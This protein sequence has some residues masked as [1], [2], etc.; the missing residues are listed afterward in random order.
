MRGVLDA[1]VGNLRRP[2]SVRASIENPAVPISSDEV[3][4]IIGGQLDSIAGVPVTEKK[5]LGYTP[6][7]RG[8]NTL[9][10][11][12]AKV[13]LYV[14]RREA[15][16]EN[17]LR[18]K[19]HP[20]YWLLR[21][22]PNAHLKPFTWKKVMFQH[23]LMRGNGYSFIRRPMRG[24]RPLSLHM[25]PPTPITT[26]IYDSEVG[27][28]FYH[29]NIRGVD[30]LYRAEDVVHLQGMTLDGIAGLEGVDVLSVMTDAIGVQLAQ[31][32]HTGRFFAAGTQTVG[33]LHAP[34]RFTEDQLE[35]IRGQWPGLR[36]EV[37]AAHSLALLYGQGLQYTPL[38]IDP[39][40]SQ[41]VQARELGMIE[42]ANMLGMPA[43]KVGSSA[44]VSYNSL[45][46]ENADYL[47]T[48]LDQWFVAME[49]ELE[50]KLLTVREQEDD[51]LYIEFDRE[52]LLRVDFAARIRGYI[53]LRE[54]GGMTGNQV[55]SRLG[56]PL[57]GAAGNR[58]Y[59][60]QTWVPIDDQGLP[61]RAS[62][63]P[64]DGDA[65]DATA[66]SDGARCAHRAAIA[67]AAS[68]V[69]RIESRRLSS[70]NPPTMSAAKQWTAK[71]YAEIRA[72]LA[73]ELAFPVAAYYASAD[74]SSDCQLA[75]ERVAESYVHL[76][77]GRVDKL[78]GAG[79]GNG[80]DTPAS[81]A[82]AAPGW[83]QRA[84]EVA[85]VLCPI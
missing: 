66:L 64:D 26:P 18:A 69:L 34:K 82:D 48:T 38:G 5:A 39:E 83:E 35:A 46:Q 42:T 45:E 72:M 14:M 84:A 74:D 17:A 27:E 29:T 2:A 13:P 79:G 77:H 56:M 65:D 47:Q 21:K 32:R 49:E 4:K 71:T 6:F 81:L 80:S 57:Q 59:I 23:A 40:K 41:L 36:A 16:N 24:G 15:E 31:Q 67:Q 62:E 20:A 19:K 58:R 30:R 9:S 12:L 70:Y 28:L 63:E 44:R 85:A 7:W 68:R 11:D 75:C 22:Q 33:F 37:D 55:A 10:G 25:L 43:H 73:T 60:P 51:E 8:V 61:V 1:I 54:K 52:Q 50:T 78:L 53:M 76:A 3:M